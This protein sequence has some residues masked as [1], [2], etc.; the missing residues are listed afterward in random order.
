MSTLTGCLARCSSAPSGDCYQCLRDNWTMQVD[1]R[2]PFFVADRSANLLS[3][4][5]CDATTCRSTGGGA[6]GQQTVACGVTL[7]PGA[8]VQSGMCRMK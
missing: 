6:L 3:M 8:Q 2:A 7:D 4:F 5:A 1:Q